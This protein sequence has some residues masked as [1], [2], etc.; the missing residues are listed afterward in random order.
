MAVERDSS[1]TTYAPADTRELLDRL[2]DEGHEIPNP[3]WT[4]GRLDE[5]EKKAADVPDE[6]EDGGDVSSEGDEG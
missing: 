5:R 2:R 1:Y 3:V 4:V 6:N